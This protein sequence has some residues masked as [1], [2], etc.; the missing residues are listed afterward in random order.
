MIPNALTRIRVAGLRISLPA[1]LVVKDPELLEAHLGP[2]AE[3]WQ[4][5]GDIEIRSG[6][7]SRS[8]GSRSNAREAADVPGPGSPMHVVDVGCFRGAPIDDPRN[9]Q[10]YEIREEGAGLVVRGD[11][12]D[13]V[14]AVGAVQVAVGRLLPL[15]GGLLL[16][17]SAVEVGGRA[18]LFPGP[19][20]T[21]K[22]TAAAAVP[23]AAPIGEDR[24]VVRR[25][26]S[27]WRVG[28]IPTWGGKYAPV[29]AVELPAAALLLIRKGHRLAVRPVGL[30]EALPRLMVSVIQAPGVPAPAAQI[31][32]LV[33]ELAALPLVF[34]LSYRLGD[35]F[36]PA[37]RDAV[38][39]GGERPAEPMPVSG[40]P[41]RRPRGEVHG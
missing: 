26:E 4:G 3:A 24:C 21:G 8:A 38:A 32:D 2:F 1:D 29:P 6:A 37:L 20:G 41:E 30:P 36:W 28:S 7:A 13:T 39:A 23:G 18:Y 14:A 31:L 11:L 5:E 27:G 25:T 22:S 19:S 17:A 9:R 35:D 15:R 34:E 16:H 40:R 33:S 10:T 12:P